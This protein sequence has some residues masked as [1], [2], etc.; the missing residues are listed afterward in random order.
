MQEIWNGQKIRNREEIS[1]RQERQNR[2]VNQ[3]KK[4]ILVVSFGTSHK[5]TRSKT[6]EQVEKDIG[7][8]YPGYKIYR[9]FTSGL[10]IN[11]LKKRDGILVMTV[12]E[13]LEQMFK[14]GMEEVIVQP[15]HILNGLENENMMKEVQSH[16]NLFQSIKTGYPLLTSTQDYHKVITCLLEVS[17]VLQKKEAI[18][19]MGHGTTHY[20]NTS[21][22]AL[23]YMFRD[24]GYEDIYVATVE[25]YPALGDVMKQFKKK[26]YRKIRL[27]PFMIVSGDHAINDMAGEEDSWKSIL[28]KEGYEVSCSLKGLGEYK[29][30]RNIF[31]EHIAAVIGTGT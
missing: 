11:V 27:I 22:A 17:P 26:D 25:A 5:E 21:Y 28:E 24:Y 8:A 18:L 29:R 30:I 12:K 1:N 4:A 9:A 14:E 7:K 31:V 16:E 15:T 23:E 10:I 2:K 13:A 3:Y 20:S 19:F 6:I